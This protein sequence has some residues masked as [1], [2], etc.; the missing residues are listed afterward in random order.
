MYNTIKMYA[1]LDQ[2]PEKFDNELRVQNRHSEPRSYV[3]YFCDFFLCCIWFDSENIVKGFIHDHIL[4]ENNNLQ[5]CD[6]DVVIASVATKSKMTTE[7]SHFMTMCMRVF[8][9]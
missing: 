8:S 1:I 5:F 3:S 9:R 7:T 4:V 6:S 2:K